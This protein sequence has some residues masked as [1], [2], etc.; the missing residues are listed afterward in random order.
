[1]TPPPTDLRGSRLLITGGTGSIGSAV[2]RALLG[3]PVAAVR[4]LGRSECSQIELRDRLPPDPRLEWWIGDVRDLER[5]REAVR[6]IDTVVHAAAM[7]HVS[8]CEENPT[9]ADATNVRG[10][11]HLIRAARQEGVERFLLLSTDKAVEPAGVLGRSKREAEARLLA[12]AREGAG[13][14]SIALRLGNVLGSRGS[15]LPRLRDRVRR[16]EPVEVGARNTTRFLL[17]LADAADHVLAALR[18]GG[19]GEILAPPLPAAE[20][21]LLI[22]R[23]IERFAARLGIDARTVQRRPRALSAGEKPHESL[24]AR[25]EAAHLAVDDR[26]YRIG[27]APRRAAP[28]P[29]PP[30]CRSESAPR[31]DAEEIAALLGRAEGEALLVAGP[32]PAL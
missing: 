7:K 6:G 2:V 4:V 1:M 32:E 14:R 3:H 20:V 28:A 13:P 5:M 31:L 27:P 19:D 12:A 17:T 9:E 16:G 23:A 22:E 30:G 10:T 15:V 11:E 8:I 18:E 29:L 21:P 25:A 26:W 24:V